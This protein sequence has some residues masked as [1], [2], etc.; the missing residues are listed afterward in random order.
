MHPSLE[1]IV[2]HPA[3][4]LAHRLLPPQV[5]AS[6]GKGVPCLI[7]LH[8]VGASEANLIDVALRLDPRLLII[9][10]RGPLAFGPAQFGW[11]NVSF[12]TGRPEIHAE[13]A[14]Q[15][16]TTLTQFIAGLPKAYG[17]DPKRIWIA[18]FSQGGIMSAS[19]ALTRPDLI[20]GFAILSGRILPEI[21][22]L[23]ASNEQTS[24]LSAFVS[25]GI[26]D[27]KLTV[28]FARSAR[29]LLEQKAVRLAY[30][31]YDAAHELSLAMQRD[32]GVWL[33]RQLDIPS[34]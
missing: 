23:T 5:E 20:T 19:V 15:S 17:V 34:E 9:L 7:L 10:A 24:R 29:H 28:E 1:Q 32:F 16:R 22:P 4:P 30:H 31:E 8:G 33:Q 25:H 11:F 27:G 26:N 3:L 12:A 18:G 14:E 13:Q 6:S 21:A 2:T